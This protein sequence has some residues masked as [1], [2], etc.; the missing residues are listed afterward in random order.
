MSKLDYLR[1]IRR[2]NVDLDSLPG[3]YGEFVAFLEA[4]PFEDHYLRYCQTFAGMLRAGIDDFGARRILETGNR[5]PLLDF[6]AGKGADC[7][8]SAADLRYRIDAPA[9]SYDLVLSLEMIGDI[10]DPANIAFE[11]T[12]PFRGGG[13][14]RYAAEVSRVLKPGGRLV[15]TAEN[16]CSI[17]S[18]Q[19]L[20]GFTAPAVYRP[21]LREYTRQE[22]AGLF[23]QLRIEE[24][25][26]FYSFYFL[27]LAE[28]QAWRAVFD[29]HG[30]DFEG[31]GDNHFFIFARPD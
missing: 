18:L 13:V 19:Q 7:V 12:A 29:A 31:R 22:L 27:E 8:N 5:S 15:L 3:I 24:Y 14:R 10:H 17:R 28:R 23:P 6:L 16:P 30:W 26:D 21:H 4:G 20:V 2:R 25:C 1:G 9:D 11:Q